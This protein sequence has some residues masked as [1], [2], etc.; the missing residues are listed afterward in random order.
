MGTRRA[1]YGVSVGIVAAIFLVCA[2]TATAQE[3]Q[4]ESSESQESPDQASTPYNASVG[5]ER[6]QELEQVLR[7]AYPGR[8][9]V[10]DHRLRFPGGPDIAMEDGT[11]RKSFEELIA[12]PDI[13]DMFT[14]SYPREMPGELPRENK[15][16]GRIRH[17]GF[18]NAMYGGSE[19]R[20]LAR[21]TTVRWL[22]EHGGG[23]L[24][25]TTVN[26]VHQRVREL[27][28][29]LSELPDRL[30]AYLVP[31]GGAFNFREI[32]G[33]ERLSPHSYGIAIDVNTSK[34]RYW[35]WDLD[36][37]GELRYD[38]E[39]PERIVE[40]FEQH[41]FI[42]GGKWYHYDSFHFEYRPELLLAAGYELSRTVR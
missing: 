37:Y 29:A 11:A 18:F 34:G 39:F 13:A 31:T 7:R 4:S 30:I 35:R 6:L 42:W 9:R 41:G 5:S 23:L 12:D 3:S 33:T 28:D 1:A 15:D 16:P 24:R 14:F 32:A 22:P 17:T 27:S 19:Q 40:I 8:F 36:S 10:Q 38:E 25:V 26:N 20:V 2:G 21:L